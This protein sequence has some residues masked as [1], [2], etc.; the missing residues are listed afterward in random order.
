MC[1]T[2]VADQSVDCFLGD[3]WQGIASGFPIDTTLHV[4]GQL[5]SFLES[6]AGRKKE[7]SGEEHE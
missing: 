7:R 2:N 1:V 3:L 4:V 5:L 6:K